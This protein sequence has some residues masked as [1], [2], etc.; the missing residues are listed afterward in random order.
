MYNT[1]YTL[2]YLTM[3]T[4]YLDH[5]V[6]FKYTNDSCYWAGFLAADGNIDTNGTISIE[7]NNKDLEAILA[8]KSFCKAE[9]CISH[10]EEKNSSRIRFVSRQIKEDL[11][12][13][14][15]ITVNKTHTMPLP[16]LTSKENYAAFFRG[17]F[18]GDGCLTEFFS[19]RPTASYRVYL[20][21]GSLDFLKDSLELLNALEV[22]KGGSISKKSPNCWHIQLGVINATSFL[23]WIY[24]VEGFSLSRKYNKYKDLILLGNRKTI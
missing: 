11:E 9:H 14:Y 12:Y 1:Y 7:L 20:T 21:N 16:I 6:F 19:N 24:S 8:F 15:S 18:D 22:I 4:K 2:F 10:N 23:K 13:N 3:S 17:F 5:S